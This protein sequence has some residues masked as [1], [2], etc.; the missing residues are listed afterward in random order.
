MQISLDSTSISY[1]IIQV[2]YLDDKKIFKHHTSETKKLEYS[3]DK[4]PKGMH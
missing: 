1:N 3:F 4:I 2:H